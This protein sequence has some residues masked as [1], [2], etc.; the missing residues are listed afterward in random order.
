MTYARRLR[1]FALISM[2]WMLWQWGCA[3]SAEEVKTLTTNGIRDFFTAFFKT[4]L[5]N[6]LDNAF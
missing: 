3:L 1:N 4:G 2:P 5:G 6:I